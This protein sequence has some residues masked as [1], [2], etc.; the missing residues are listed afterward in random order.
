MT[1]CTAN[2]HEDIERDLVLTISVL[3]TI[4]SLKQGKEYQILF[5]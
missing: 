1:Q 5:S 3:E 4:A 2:D